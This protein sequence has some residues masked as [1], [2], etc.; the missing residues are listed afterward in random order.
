M[1]EPA[2]VLTWQ[3]KKQVS[4][5]NSVSRSCTIFFFTLLPLKKGL[6]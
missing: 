5:M 1:A 2:G 4:G 6:M 3:G